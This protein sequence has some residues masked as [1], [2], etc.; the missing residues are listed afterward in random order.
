MY[1]ITSREGLYLFDKTTASFTL[2]KEGYF[3]GL[4]RFND[5]WY[6]FGYKGDNINVKNYPTFQGYIA[7]F[8]L[9][10]D[11]IIEEWLERCSNLD[12]GSHQIRIH[13][14]KLYLVETYIQTISIFDID[15]SGSLCLKKQVPIYKTPHPI[16]NAHYVVNGDD[17]DYS[18][19]GY[20]HINALTIQDDLIYMSCP[21]L[22]NN[23]TAEGK[24][25]QALS[26]HVIEVY[27]LNF[28]FLWSFIIPNEVFCHDIVFQGQ[29]FYF[30]APPNK[31]CCYDI[32][33]KMVT[34][35]KELNASA[36]HPRGLSIHAD[37]TVMVG[38]R[39]QGMLV[40]YNLKD[41]NVND[42]KY[43]KAPCDPCFI[44]SIDYDNDFN[45]N[46]SPLVKSYVKQI[47]LN[48]LPIDLGILEDITQR[49][50]KY[51]WTSYRDLRW[52]KKTQTTNLISS[53][54]QY[55]LDEDSLDEVLAPQTEI[56]DNICNL[57]NTIGKKINMVYLEVTDELQREHRVIIEMLKE[58]EK[59][60]EQ[61]A[62]RIS[63]HLYL[64]PPQSALGWHTNL[65]EPYNHNTIRCYVVNTT[66]DNETFFLYKHP[67]SKLIHAV[68]DRNKFVNI[69]SLGN[70]SSPLWHAVYNGSTDVHRLSLGI[71]CHQYRLGAFHTIKDVISDII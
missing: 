53:I 4:A 27:N 31:V 63:G 8:K 54:K 20:K 12:N 45:N 56:F 37:G 47:H 38:L 19:H 26:P 50:F 69:F 11:L 43:S 9:T 36:F 32:V 40:Y 33:K 61:R 70:P 7:S 29:K 23:V 34:S 71:A 51:N 46:D 22:R 3:F 14:S 58:V 42:I 62:L 52:E 48:E 49:V 28:D 41:T 64:Y 6:I 17:K 59:R 16:V 5:L 21:S 2:L 30:N 10:T 24:A 65:E 66:K 15:K 18:C 25:T 60:V 68:P 35:T 55:S 1:L 57:Q 13:K 44:A 67:I 39:K